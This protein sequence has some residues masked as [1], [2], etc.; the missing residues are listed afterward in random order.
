MTEDDAS[1]P[2]TGFY[3]PPSAFRAGRITLPDDEAHHAARVLRHQ[4]GDEVVVVDGE[5][6]WYRVRL[7]VVEKRRVAG[8]VLE[9]AHDV[10]EPSYHLRIGLALLK[11]RSR[12]ETFLEKA[13]ELGVSDV[14][15]LRT[16][17]TERAHFKQSRGEQILV[18]AMK[19]SR[20][21][22][23]VTLAEPRDFEA[24][25]AEAAFDLSLIAHERIDPEDHL[26]AVLARHPEARRLRV[27][28]GPE[29]GFSEE[30]IRAAEAAGFR[31]VSLGPR[32]LRAETA[33]LAAAT[34]VML[35][36]P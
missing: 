28:V 23:L 2:T 14:V 29:G 32:R 30:E 19:Q 4:P 11:N 10:G 34:A 1:E 6:G 35:A 20:R 31:P 3:A 12:Y 16:A 26:L 7:D 27:L 17:H 9:A 36:R 33:A 22:R 15:P 8:A 13:V 18:A 5:G 25:L 21:S 24:E